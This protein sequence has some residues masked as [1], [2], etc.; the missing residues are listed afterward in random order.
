MSKVIFIRIQD[1]HERRFEQNPNHAPG[2]AFNKIEL[3]PIS[4]HQPFEIVLDYSHLPGAD[5]WHTQTQGLLPVDSG[6]WE[7]IGKRIENPSFPFY[8][9][10]SGEY[11][12]IK[13]SKKDGA[14][15]FLTL[16]KTNPYGDSWTTLTS[17][18]SGPYI[19][20]LSGEGHYLKNIVPGGILNHYFSWKCN[21]VS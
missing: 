9:L 12:S 11:V 10:H 18:F 15:E 17:F 1:K 3:E 21:R 13:T 8:G 4:A 14:K 5:T 20:G 6:I 2:A 19:G 16:E 7:I